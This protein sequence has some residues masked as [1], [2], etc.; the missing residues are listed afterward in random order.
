MERK[1]SQLHMKEMSKYFINKDKEKIKVLNEINL[2]I[3]KG[4][5]IS[6]FGPNGC[7]KS[8]LMNI[9]AGI[10]KQDSGRIIFREEPS[11][12]YVFQDFRQSLLPWKSVMENIALPLLIRGMPKKEAYKHVKRLVS[13][14]K[15]DLNIDAYPYM[16][17]GGQAQMVSILRALIINP[18]ILII[19]E[20]FSALDYTNHLDM[21]LKIRELHN[22]RKF[23][24]LFVSHNID[25]GIL[26]G[27]KLILLSNKPTEIVETFDIN[28][29]AQRKINL[30]TA[31]EFIKIK[32]DA[33]K[34]IERE[35]GKPNPNK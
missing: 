3:N 15:I 7:G 6:F 20:P 5:F 1:M 12:G 34:I 28:L 13:E 17:S 11:I 18:D 14:T 35:Y 31:D 19:D 2:K 29:P 10:E 21:I 22:K 8:T 27:D 4:E 33:L 23:T 16:L 26:I 30:M 25:E 24:V 9:I 32:T